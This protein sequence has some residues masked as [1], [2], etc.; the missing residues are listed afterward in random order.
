M[1][2]SGAKPAGPPALEDSPA[3]DGLRSYPFS[4]WKLAVLAALA[5]LLVFFIAA[6]LD[7]LVLHENESIKI[8]IS[9]SDSLAALIAGVLV[10]RLLQ[11][12]RDRRRRLRQRLEIIAEMNHHVRN[13]L[14]VISLSA[15]SSADQEQLA[16]IKESVN[17]IQWALREILPKM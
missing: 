5:A 3:A 16:A 9:V 7:W 17:R 2:T 1:S 6:G 10:F 12:E 13:A 15:Y 11:F 14:Q 4:N 8:A